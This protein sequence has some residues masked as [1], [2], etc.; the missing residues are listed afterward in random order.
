MQYCPNCHNALGKKD[1]ICPNCGFNVEQPTEVIKPQ[2]EQ[3]DKPTANIPE[4]RPLYKRPVFW[5][6]TTSAILILLI[7]CGLIG[8]YFYYNYKASVD[9][10]AQVKSSWT[11][12]VADS[13][14]LDNTL[15]AVQTEADL[16]MLANELA[17]MEDTLAETQSKAVNFN[18]PKK[19]RQQQ[20]ELLKALDNYASYIIQAKIMANKE[21]LAIDVAKFTEL[22]AYAE[23]AKTSTSNFVTETDFIDQQLPEEIFTIGKLFKPIIED[24]KLT[25][26]KRK[27]KQKKQRAASAKKQA[28]QTV[29]SFMQARIHKDAA[30]MRKYL[31]EAAAKAFD[32]DLEFQGDFDPIDFKIVKTDANS[33]GFLIIGDETDRSWEGNNFTTKWQFQVILEGGSWLIDHRKILSSSK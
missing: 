2:K 3:K 13:K 22:D 1:K 32:P 33:K 30:E 6:I 7:A 20:A 16:P 9:Y 31:T 14:S 19:Y 8:G 27:Q 5:V 11:D 18:P 15:K 24:A 17:S 25:D 4:K 23:A 12:V 26:K 10:K 29:I 28:Q 21:P